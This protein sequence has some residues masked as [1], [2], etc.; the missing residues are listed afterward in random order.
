LIRTMVIDRQLQVELNVPLEQLSH[1]SVLWYWVDFNHPT[2]EEADLL[3]EHFHF[4]P[5]AIEDCTHY[6]QRPKLDHYEDADFFVLH[7]IHKD[8][9]ESLEIDLFLGANFL[10]SFHFDPIVEIDEAWAQI[11]NES[12]FRKRGHGYAAYLLMD[13]LVDQYF[14]CV[15]LIEG[16][17]DKLEDRGI[18]SSISINQL[19]NQ[20]FDIRSKLLQ[21]RRTILPMRD[22][23][24][25]MLSSDK[26]TAISNQKVYFSDIYDHLIRLSEM[27]ESSREITA[28]MRDSYISMNAHRMNAIMKTL[29]V[30]TTIFMPLTFIAGVYGMN[31]KN[32][33]ELNWHWGYFVILTFMGILGFGMFFLFKRKGWFE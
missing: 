12:T 6:M 16:E 21:L 29:T 5:L 22:L 27:V 10:V 19:M 18:S 1:D 31:F 23:L 33:P 25:R 7:A 26:I 17:L 15:H 28:D 11:A 24:D 30:I 8:T 13:K 20:V 14:P 32:M 9:F 2:S 3:H 4:H